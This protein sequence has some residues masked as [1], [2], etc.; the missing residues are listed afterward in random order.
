VFL[1]SYQN[2]S[3]GLARYYREVL[4][5][6]GRESSPQ[7]LVFRHRMTSALKQPALQE[8]TKETEP[9]G[10]GGFWVWVK[11][12]GFSILVLLVASGAVYVAWKVEV[13][14]HPPNFA[15]KSPSV[16][17]I[18]VGAA[19]FLGLYL[20]VMTF[21][22]ALHN[23]GFSEIGVNGLRAQEIANIAQQNAIR[24][25]DEQVEALRAGLEQVSG[26]VEKTFEQLKSEMDELKREM[27]RN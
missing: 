23:R 8:P 22:L 18:E 19:C 2:V 16:Y 13:P 4:R 10:E 1:D 9:V 5:G 26:A 27:G 11:R 7:R 24:G 21:V 25:Q 17:R 15:L 3:I 20:V 14:A 12:W 6:K